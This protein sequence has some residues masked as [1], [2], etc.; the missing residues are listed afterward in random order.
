MLFINHYDNPVW[1]KDKVLT[2]NAVYSEKITGD[3]FRTDYLC[4]LSSCFTYWKSKF[5]V[6]SWIRCPE[7]SKQYDKNSFKQ[8]ETG[9]TYVSIHWWSI[10]H[11]PLIVLVTRSLKSSKAGESMQFNKWRRTALSFLGCFLL[12]VKHEIPISSLLLTARCL[13]CFQ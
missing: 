10:S 11:L 13:S 8:I 1:Y 9:G 3:A 7:C 2:T 6:F 12:L 5:K 4:S